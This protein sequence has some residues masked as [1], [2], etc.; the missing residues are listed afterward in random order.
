[1]HTVMGIVAQNADF[2]VSF[3]E[4]IFNCGR[5]LSLIFFIGNEV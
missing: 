4:T 5:Q 1:M 2:T 3:G